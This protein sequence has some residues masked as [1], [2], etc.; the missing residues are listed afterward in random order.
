MLYKG[1]R[2][3]SEYLFTKNKSNI[4]ELSIKLKIN[5]DT[6]RRAINSLKEKGYVH[7]KKVTSLL[8]KPKKELLE[9][10]DFRFP[11]FS[12]TGKTE[13]SKLTNIEKQVGL[14]WAKRKNLIDIN[15]NKI[16]IK[17]DVNL[18]KKER[19]FIK[20]VNMIIS[21]GKKGYNIL[22]DDTT[23]SKET[24]NRIKS[25]FDE[26]QKRRLLDISE[27]NQSN[28]EWIGGKFNETKEFD[29]KTPVE[30]AAIGKNHPIT[31]LGN[32]IRN[33][34]TSLG[35]E[36]IEGDMINSAFWNFDALFQPQDHPARELAD[37]FYIDGKTNLP[38][39]EIVSKIKATHEN[40]WKYNWSEEVARRL[41]L[42]THTTVISAKKLYTHKKEGKFFSLGRVFRNETT[43]PTHLAEFYQ[44]EGIIIWKNANFRNLLG[45]LKSFYERIGFD[46]IRFSPSYFPYTEPSLEIEVFFKERNEWLELGGAGIFRPEVTKSL[47]GCY[48]V[49]AW[50]LSLE[51]PLMLSLKLDDIRELYNNDAKFLRETILH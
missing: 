40:G 2:E 30:S 19:E 22:Y 31:T 41:V 38:N 14:A 33:V 26:L 17:E 3:I 5:I 45:I 1:E 15:K 42:R 4:N 50:G 51:R 44:V 20:L 32:K 47:C 10:L 24:K 39:P 8:I 27:I 36:E 23:I 29:M 21:K 28:I 11:E 46:K 7:V 35:F 18:E 9:Y 34:F 25:T 16:F 37:T 48:P 6:V 49:L 43:D 12:L 13:I